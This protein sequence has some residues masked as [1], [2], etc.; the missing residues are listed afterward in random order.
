MD[1]TFPRTHFKYSTGGPILLGWPF[2]SPSYPNGTEPQ[3]YLGSQSSLP[4]NTTLNANLFEA[5]KLGPT[6]FPILFAGAVGSFLR[7]LARKR[8]EQGSTIEV[9]N[10]LILQA[11]GS[12]PTKGYVVPRSPSREPITPKHDLDCLLP[13]SHKSGRNRSYIFVDVISNWRPSLFADA[14]H[15]KYNRHHF[16]LP[17]DCSQSLYSDN[18]RPGRLS[19]NKDSFH[20]NI[21]F[22]FISL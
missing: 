17:L 8:A 6:I 9:R 14:K 4:R 22:H 18:N 19:R 5:A 21:H 12:L 13:W 20:I 1:R 3:L 15:S 10:H 2:F 7:L 11:T 16:K